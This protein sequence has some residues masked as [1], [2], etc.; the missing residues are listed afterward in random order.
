MENLANRKVVHQKSYDT[1]FIATYDQRIIYKEK[2]FKIY[3]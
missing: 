3:I 1:S 2:I